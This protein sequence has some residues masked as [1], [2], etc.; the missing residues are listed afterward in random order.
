MPHLGK[1]TITLET[2]DRCWPEVA[3]RIF[4]LKVCIW[5]PPRLLV[6]CQWQ[7]ARLH[8]YIRPLQMAYADA[9]P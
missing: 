9:G 8:T 7:L 4:E 6:I 3:P 5:T 1:C 2:N